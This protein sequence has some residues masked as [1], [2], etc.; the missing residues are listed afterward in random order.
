[1]NYPECL[2]Y[3]ERIQTLGIKFGLD[4]VR[5]VL[6]ALENPEK[7]F[8]SVV[9]AGSNGKGS[10]CAMLSRIL[11]VH[12][13]KTGLY[14]SPHLVHPEERIRID[15]VPVGRETFCRSLT[16]VK[17]AVDSLVDEAILLMPPTY[18]ETITCQACLCFAEAQVDMAVL[19][20]GMGGRF[21]ATNVVDRVVSIITTISAEHQKFL[22]DS[23]G[24]IAFEKAGIVKKGV[25]VVCGVESDEAFDVIKARAEEL[26]APFI[27]VFREGRRL[28]ERHGYTFYFG[29]DEH[30]KKTSIPPG[31]DQ[32]AGENPGY[33][34]RPSLLGLHQ[35]KNAAVA[36]RAAEVISE[37]W[38][39]LKKNKIIEGIESTS[40]PGRLEIVSDNPLVIMDGAH[41]EEGARVLRAYAEKFMPKPLTLI[42]G[43]MRDKA[44]GRIAEILFPAA[45]LIILTRFSY[46]KAL[47]PDEILDKTPENLKSRCILESDS[48]LALEK[49]KS[50]ISQVKRGKEI[51]SVFVGSVLIAG[52]LFLV[53]EMRPLF[54]YVKSP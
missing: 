13:F 17:N 35:G 19:E 1:M 29:G 27:P 46:F 44:V 14:T 8:P 25:P 32:N 11:T 21:D 45:D 40:W 39:P 12:G 4:N 47:L 52:S 16:A 36:I 3:L 2:R 42:F 34:F 7:L 22:G 5:A 31:R 30:V 18:F 6:K 38:K 53:G 37:A 48:R 54:R 43:A 26:S 15:G 41:N 50:Q 23:L 28:T 24:Q 10:V 20:V 51:P 49:A 33:V 9:V